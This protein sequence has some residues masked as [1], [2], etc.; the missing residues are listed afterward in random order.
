MNRK[1]LMVILLCC[2]TWVFAQTAGSSSGQSSSGSGNMGQSS[3]SGSMQSG[4]QGGM[5]SGHMNGHT[6]ITGCLNQQNGNYD[7]KDDSTGTSYSLYGKDNLGQYVG[8]KVEVQ[9][10]QTS[11]SQ[12]VTSNKA[13]GVGQQAPDNPFHV[14]SI[15]AAGGSCGSASGTSGSAQQP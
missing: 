13:Q 2:G 3:S 1:L 5:S 7:L 14:K 4:S 9:G 11:T 15:K 6:K 8:K 10:M 12:Q